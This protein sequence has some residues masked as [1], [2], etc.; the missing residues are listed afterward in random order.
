VG[1][2]SRG[3]P[4]ASTTTHQAASSNGAGDERSGTEQERQGQEAPGR[5]AGWEG[6]A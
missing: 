2:A 5:W 4:L 6:K 1:G 3:V